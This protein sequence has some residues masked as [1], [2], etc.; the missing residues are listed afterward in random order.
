MIWLF[1]TK[2]LKAYKKVWIGYINIAKNGVCIT[3]NTVKTKVVVFRKGG[4][5]GKKCIWYYGGVLLEVVPFFKYLGVYIS[6]GGSFSHN[7]KESINKARRAIFTL[8][9]IFTKNRE[10]LPKMK[11]NLFNSL[12]Q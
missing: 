8:N 10:I 7:I 12:I 9:R 4:V 5:I 6:S 11:I 3:V 1:S 2:L